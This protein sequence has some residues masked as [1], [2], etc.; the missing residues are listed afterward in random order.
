MRLAVPAI[1]GAGVDAGISD[2]F[3]ESRFFSIVSVDG[4][5]INKD[6]E[7]IAVPAGED[8][9][10]IVFMLLGRGVGAVVAKALTERERQM[11]AGT[12][13][14]VHVG[15]AGTVWDAVRSYIDGRL[16]DRSDLNPCEG[17]CH[18]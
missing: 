15:A 12:G 17:H 7:S 4:D 13:M 16:E 14:Q 3:S 2:T 1:N 8:T 11:I 18:G 9:G 6:F 10:K 5:R